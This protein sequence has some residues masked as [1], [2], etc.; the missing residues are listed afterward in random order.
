MAFSARSVPD[1]KAKGLIEFEL[2]ALIRAEQTE[3]F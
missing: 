2:R 3:S 1:P